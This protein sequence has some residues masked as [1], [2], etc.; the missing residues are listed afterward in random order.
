MRGHVINAE[1][2][3]ELRFAA[4]TLFVHNGGGQLQSYDGQEWTGLDGA[5]RVSGLG[6]SSIGQSRSV[7]IGLDAEDAEIKILFKEQRQD[8]EGR[9]VI[10]WVQF[11]DENLTPL[12]AKFHHYTGIADRLTMKKQGPSSRAMDLSLEDFFARRRRSAHGVVTHAD[13]QMRDPTAIGF[14]YQADMVDKIINLYDAKD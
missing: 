13:Q 5:G 3:F 2:L 12:D 1:T 9:K 4:G 8:V 11:Y 14:I 6:A 10:A 7:T